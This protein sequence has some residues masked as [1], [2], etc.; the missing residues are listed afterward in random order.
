MS[1]GFLGASFPQGILV[2]VI[3]PDPEKPAAGCSINT[4]EDLSEL[5]KTL[6][7]AVI[8]AVP[9]AFTPTC[10]AQHLPGFIKHADEI[11]SKGVNEIF[12]L[13]VNDHFVMSAWGQAT[14]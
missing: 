6:D 11:R 9:G 13:S 1:A 5:L 12:A 8:F 10:S 2:D 3:R 14:P 4:P 7:K